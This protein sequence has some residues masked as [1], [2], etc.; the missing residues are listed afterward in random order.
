M[1]YVLEGNLAIEHCLPFKSVYIQ[2]CCGMYMCV[3]V[4]ICIDIYIY[5]YI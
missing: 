2:M 4:C 5:I 3:C 1:L